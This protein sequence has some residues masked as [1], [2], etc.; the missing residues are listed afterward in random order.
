MAMMNAAPA[1]INHV[2]AE[3][4]RNSRHM[5]YTTMPITTVVFSV[6]PLGND[7]E[8]SNGGT[9]STWSGRVRPS[10]VLPTLVAV[11]ETAAAPPTRISGRQLRLT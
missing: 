11:T 9:A 4:F 7:G 10:R 5:R 1:M 8:N 3:V 6:C 2:R